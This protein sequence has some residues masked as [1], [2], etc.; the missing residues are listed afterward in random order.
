MVGL[1]GSV[2]PRPKGPLGII[3]QGEALVGPP[4]GRS[5]ALHRGLPS[6]INRRGLPLEPLQLFLVDKPLE[7]L[8]LDMLDVVREDVGPIQRVL[9]ISQSRDMLVQPPQLTQLLRKG[10]PGLELGGVS[11]LDLKDVIEIVIVLP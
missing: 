1:E 3:G 8:M 5:S 10:P 2:Q 7:G 6:G 11:V 4:L 9:G